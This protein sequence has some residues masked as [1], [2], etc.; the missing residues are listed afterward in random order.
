M[1]A[2]PILVLVHGAN[3]A[4][5]DIADLEAKVRSEII[6]R[7]LPV[8]ALVMP[9]WRDEAGM[10]LGPASLAVRERPVDARPGDFLLTMASR[11]FGANRTMAMATDL[12][13]EF[14]P[15]LMARL[16]YQLLGDVSAYGR[17][18]GRIHEVL[19]SAIAPCAGKVV[20]VGH[21]LGGV[22]LVDLMAERPEKNVTA[23]ITVGS[24][25][26]LLCT[27]DALEGLPYG[28]KPF[29]P[30]INVWDSR[31]HLSFFARD[32]FKLRRDNSWPI[33]DVEVNS[34]QPVREAHS[35]Y[36]DQEGTWAAIELALRVSMQPKPLPDAHTTGEKLVEMVAGVRDAD[37]ADRHRLVE[38]WLDLQSAKTEHEMAEVRLLLQNVKSQTAESDLFEIQRGAFL[39]GRVQH[40]GAAYF[41]VSG[42]FYVF[43]SG[44]IDEPRVQ[45]MVADYSTL[46]PDDWTPNSSP[47]LVAFADYSSTF[48]EKTRAALRNSG[49]IIRVLDDERSRALRGLVARDSAPGPCAPKAKA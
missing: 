5:A 28:G 31:D 48:S 11:I 1:N 43:V 46:R 30:W 45:R 17:R 20:L 44:E 27:L 29:T 7:D 21:S 41:D 8:E 22:A 47:W 49:I 42:D 26:P 18:R 10:H 38:A 6:A 13:T 23:L 39:R 12:A 34:G 9:R 3:M 25:A 4:A 2:K 15:E 37:E 14:R 33:V 35:A 24:Q 36:W 16:G 32:I 19:R 40:S